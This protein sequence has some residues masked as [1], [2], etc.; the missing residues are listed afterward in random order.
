LFDRAELDA[1]AAA[2]EREVI[3]AVAFAEASPVP[4]VAGLLDNVY[5]P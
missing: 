4:D 3:E 2:A 5:T 1:I